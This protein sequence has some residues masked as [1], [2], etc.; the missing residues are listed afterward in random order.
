MILDNLQEPR[1]VLFVGESTFQQGFGKAL[2]RGQRSL[3]FV[4]DIGN[5]VP[6]HLF[7][8]ALVSDVMQDQD[9]ALGW[10]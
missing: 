8:A 7:Q 3:E 1:P 9:Y 5:K 2:D 4:G 10:Y 6:A